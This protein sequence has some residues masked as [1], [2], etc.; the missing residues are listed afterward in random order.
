MVILK[1][2]TNWKCH[3]QVSCPPRQGGIIP[4]GWR[5][6][7]MMQCLLA[8]GPPHCNRNSPA[9]GPCSRGSKGITNDHQVQELLP[10]LSLLQLCLHVHLLPRLASLFA[11]C[12]RGAL[13]FRRRPRVSGS[14]CLGRGLR[15]TRSSAACVFTFLRCVQTMAILLG[16]YSTESN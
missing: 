1:M 15:R 3:T 4:A 9:A 11:Q 5:E 12:G 10:S 6:S 8:S 7:I 13:L 2:F 14:R 16:S